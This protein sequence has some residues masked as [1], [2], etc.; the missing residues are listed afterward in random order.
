MPTTSPQHNSVWRATAQLPE[1][2]PLGESLSTG[3]CVVGA[4]L[5][6]MTTAY[7]LLRE[8]EEVV[9]LDDGPIAGGETGGT[10]AHLN[11]ELDDGYTELER[12]FG[13]EG[14][15][16]ASDSHAA[17]IDLIESIAQEEQIDCDFERLES[18]LFGP[19]GESA[20]FLTEELGAIQR[21]GITGVDKVARAP[22]DGFDT[23]PA[24]RFA[25]QAQ[26]HVLKYLAGLEKAIT[27]RGGKI[28]LYSHVTEVVDGRPVKVTTREGHGVTAGAVV[29]ATNAPIGERLL[30]SSRQGAHRSYVIGL[31]V[32]KGAVY[33]AQY[34]DT[35]EPYHYARLHPLD[36]E[37]ELLMVGGEDH[38]TGQEDEADGRYERLERWAR[39]RFL[40]AGRVLYRWSAQLMEP[41]D[42]LAFLGRDP[43]SDNVYVIT[44]DSGMGMT[45]GTLGAMICADLIRGRDNPWAELY[46]PKRLEAGAVPTMLREGVNEISK[47]G[48]WLR[49]GEVASADEIAPGSGA[50]MRRGLGKVAVYKDEQGTVLER[51]A[52][53]SH[54]GC[55]V[56]WN[57][58]AGSWDCPCHGSRFAPDGEVLN[59]PAIKALAEV[60]PQ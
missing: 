59:G 56:A 51:S 42:A 3:V 5:S 21:A 20:E 47:L 33:P 16:L 44:G 13:S 23:G 35:A 58:E 41:F 57:P 39:E 38:K 18:Y 36:D 27:R 25:N 15:K 10:T 14:L 24:L 60:E 54:L 40:A 45:H 22:L 9:V 1:H 12:L 11:S 48:H 17:A 26:F 52:V 30:Y 46:S 28:F 50:V 7:L 2:P 8:G 29:L 19:P 55:I 37:R 6:G 53:C 43:G 49:A 4:G 32:A 31:E 34:A